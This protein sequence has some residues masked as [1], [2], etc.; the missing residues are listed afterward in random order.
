MSINT[1]IFIQT[2]QNY[3]VLYDTSHKDYKNNRIKNKIWNSI[4]DIIGQ[5]DGDH[6]K[7]KWKNLRD[8]YSKHLRTCK[9]TTGQA[10][11]LVDRYKT[12]PWANLMS[13]LRQHL[14]FAETS[15]NIIENTEEAG[16]S[17]AIDRT[18]P[19]NT[20]QSDTHVHSWRK[21]TSDGSQTQVDKVIEFMKNNR[22]DED[23]IE[24]LFKSYA[25]KLKKMSDR[26]QALVKFEIA[27]IMLKAELEESHEMQ[28][29]S[30]DVR[31]SENMVLKVEQPLSSAGSCVDDSKYIISSSS[32]ASESEGENKGDREWLLS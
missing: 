24:L 22:E 2:V 29:I 5:S 31:H 18:S 15:S 7:K 14:E 16:S 25:K 4:A 19:I 6:L 30:G 21:R 9:T 10:A 20:T 3:P 13:F 28:L 1:E 12:W 17:Q 8:A 11:K 23:D 27:K 32:P 26:R